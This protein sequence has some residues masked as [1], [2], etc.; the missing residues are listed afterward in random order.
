M[1]VMASLKQG[2]PPLKFYPVTKS[3]WAHFEQLFGERGA[4][5]GCW[6]MA[7]RL[8]PAAWKAG[9]D[10]GNKLNMKSLVAQGK[11]PGILVY[12]G[13]RPM[14]WCSVAPRSDFVTLQRS[15][16]L[17][18]IDG[19]SVWSISCLFVAKEYRRKGV[20]VQLL[21]AAVEHVRKQ[22]GKIIEGY[23]IVPYTDKMPDV[24]A[25]TGTVAAFKRAGFREA[26][27]RSRSRPMFRRYLSVE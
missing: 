13:K 9:K 2:R 4:C 15:R 6:C 27:R 25:W 17:A 5:G 18:S 1:P 16:V 12:D 23:P 24:F 26:A 3:R 19:K 8:P 10:G 14:G 20:S 7:W 22:G 21:R 11:I